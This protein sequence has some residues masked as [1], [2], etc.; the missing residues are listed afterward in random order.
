VRHAEPAVLDEAVRQLRTDEGG[1]LFT[2]EAPLQ[3]GAE[4]QD[5][6]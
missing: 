4:A 1:L 3:D 5:R 6:P 2:N